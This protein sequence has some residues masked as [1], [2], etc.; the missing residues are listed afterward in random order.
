MLIARSAAL[1]SLRCECC[2]CVLWSF[3]LRMSMSSGFGVRDIL[4]T[5]ARAWATRDF[6]GASTSN[7]SSTTRQRQAQGKGEEG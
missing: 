7:N 6:V 5:Q 1:H 3:L 4:K 2:L